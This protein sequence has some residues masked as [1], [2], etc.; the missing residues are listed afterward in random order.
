MLILPMSFGSF[1]V[2]IKMIQFGFPNLNVSKIA[3]YII[4]FVPK[5]RFKL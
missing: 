2:S 4:Q 1:A 5:V 3:V